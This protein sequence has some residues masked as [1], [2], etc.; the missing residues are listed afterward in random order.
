MV[1]DIILV[2]WGRQELTRATI[3]SIRRNTNRSSYRLIV[4]DNCSPYVMVPMLLDYH[5]NGDIDELI[6]NDENLGLEPARNQGMK[7]VK[8]PYFVCVDNDL[9]CPPKLDGK[10]WVQRMVGLIDGNPEYGAI[11]MRT[12]IMI[13]TG[14]IFDGKE[15]QDIVEFPHPGGSYRIMDTYA[16]RDVGGW[17]D[18]MRSRGSEERYICGKLRDIGFKTGFAVKVK[19]LHLFGDKETDNWGYPKD[20]RPEDTGHSDVWHPIFESGD[21]P[22]QIDKFMETGQ[23]E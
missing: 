19:S 10:D 5:M 16:V 13:G 15:D 21:D 17:R 22:E 23:Y 4:V 12:Q 14:N 20:W 18:N 11:A 3:D 8:N 6:L 2:T 1:V 7:Y 9:L